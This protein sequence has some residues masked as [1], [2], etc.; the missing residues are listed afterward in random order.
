VCITSKKEIR[1][2]KK[3]VSLLL[4]ALALFI[5]TGT[6]FA[7]THPDPYTLDDNTKIRW[8]YTRS[9]YMGGWSDVIGGFHDFNVHGIDLSYSG[10]YINFDMYTNFNDDGTYDDGNLFVYLADLALDVNLDG[11]YEYGVCLLDHDQWGN[12]KPSSSTQG[13]EPTL[14][15]LDVGLYSVYSWDTSSHFIESVSGYAYGGKWD[16]S[17]PKLPNVAIASV[18]TDING[19][20][21]QAGSATIG[22]TN[23]YGS[24]TVG[25]PKYKWS[26]SIDVGSIGFNS[27][28]NAVNLFWGGATCSND[29]IAGIFTIDYQPLSSGYKSSS[30][31]EPATLILTGFGLI[32]FVVIGISRGRK[33]CRKK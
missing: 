14:T 25:D 1:I 12:S 27:G 10:G 20:P 29:A 21:V 23:L 9:S 24:G 15:D 26:V 11:F 22:F 19:D 32:G 7:L 4:L 28:N 5:W 30:T 31:P 2:M 18:E 6:A 16:Q 3:M 13:N 17:D 8:D 33:H